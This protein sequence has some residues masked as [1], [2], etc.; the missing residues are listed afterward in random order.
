MQLARLQRSGVRATR[1]ARTT[2]V[3]AM[4][5]KVTLKTPSGESRPQIAATSEI[6]VSLP[7]PGSPIGA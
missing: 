2:S 1:P 7:S 5:Y 6:A 3:R 4:A